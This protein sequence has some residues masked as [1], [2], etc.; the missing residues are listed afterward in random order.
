MNSTVDNI[1]T[2]IDTV[3]I[4]IAPTCFIFCVLATVVLI[5]YVRRRYYLTV[6][7]N[8]ISREKLTYLNYQNHLKNFKIKAMISNF[9]ILIAELWI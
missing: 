9:V 3:E 6:E 8:G 1:S 2:I 5:Y 4:A 7:M